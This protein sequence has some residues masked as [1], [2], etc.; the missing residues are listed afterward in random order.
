M[1]S[2]LWEGLC[3]DS[4]MAESDSSRSWTFLVRF[5]KTG[6]LV[7]S[8]CLS[9]ACPSLTPWMQDK[10]TGHGFPEVTLAVGGTLMRWIP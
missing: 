1:V 2:S 6:M 3:P 9:C 10:C 5:C 8:S 4:L 7:T